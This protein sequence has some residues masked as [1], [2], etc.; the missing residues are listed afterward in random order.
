MVRGVPNAAKDLTVKGVP[1]RANVELLKCKVLRHIQERFGSFDALSVFTSASEWNEKYPA[2]SKHED[3]GATSG[4]GPDLVVSSALM[5]RIPVWAETS[6]S[7]IFKLCCE[8]IMLTGHLYQALLSVSRN[9]GLVRDITPITERL[10]LLQIAYNHDMNPYRNQTLPGPDKKSRVTV[11]GTDLQESSVEELERLE[12]EWVAA[13]QQFLATAAAAEMH[14]RGMCEPILFSLDNVYMHQK[15][16]QCSIISTKLSQGGSG[17]LYFYDLKQVSTKMPRGKANRMSMSVSVSKERLEFWLQEVFL[18]FGRDDDVGVIMCGKSEH[19]AK[20][21]LSL[22][23]SVRPS[24]HM[25]VQGWLYSEDALR[26]GGLQRARY[27]LSLTPR[28]MSVLF[29]KS[30]IQPAPA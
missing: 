1:A 29:S 13:K 21:V 20:K 3:E 23:S 7:E 26:S 16:S 19:T 2:L 24:L 18:T 10:D 28:E 11:P 12:S 14:S 25:R 8:V 30:P 6:K 17:I 9:S 15:L 27:M 22:L 4:T 5:P